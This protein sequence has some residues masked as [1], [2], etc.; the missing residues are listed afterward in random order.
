MNGA[1]RYGADG[2][3]MDNPTLAE[4]Y[5]AVLRVEQL[6]LKTNG[7]VQD[8]EIADARIEE[9]LVVIE[10]T[11]AECPLLRPEGTRSR[12]GEPK[13]EVSARQPLASLASPKQIALGV[14]AIGAA[15]WAAMDLLWR[16]GDWLH[17][18]G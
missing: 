11:H 5:R 12:A 4:V 17:K 2:T 16:L 15:V 7:R 10:R 3:A 8:L 18:A 13:Q 1:E 14:A 6:Q 9:R